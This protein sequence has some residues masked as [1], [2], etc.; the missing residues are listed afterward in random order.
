M[1]IFV[2]DGGYK[3]ESSCW[4]KMIMKSLPGNEVLS[5]TWRASQLHCHSPDNHFHDDDDCDDD[6]DIDGFDEDGYDDEDDD[7]DDHR[8]HDHN[9]EDDDDDDDD[10][11][12]YQVGSQWCCTTGVLTTARKSSILKRNTTVI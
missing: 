12:N 9:D 8:T 11:L 4:M 7:L 2:T 10:D 1:Q 3:E 6:D 5:R